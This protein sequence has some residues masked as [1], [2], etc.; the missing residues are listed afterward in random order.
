MSVSVQSFTTALQK[1]DSPLWGFHIVVPDEIAEPFLA[2]GSKR[3]VCSLFGEAEFQ[4]AIMV[5]GDKLEPAPP[6]KYF[7]NINKE[8]RSKFRLSV[9]DEVKAALRPDESK[10]GLPMPEEMAELLA[11]DPEGDRLFHAL[12]PGKQRSL[13]YI[14]GKPKGSE[15]RLKKS[16]VII[17]HLKVNEGK[18]DFGRLQEDFKDAN[19]GW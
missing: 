14:A 4:C 19:R 10:Y 18:I 9:G 8:L 11:Q 6:G 7:I 13:L 5:R 2:N 12:T 1:F 15:T 16:V 3:V 17:E